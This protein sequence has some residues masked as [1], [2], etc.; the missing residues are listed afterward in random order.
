MV[1]RKTWGGRGQSFF[2]ILHFH[3][4]RR[5]FIVSV[6]V[7]VPVELFAQIIL[8]LDGSG[9]ES[10]VDGLVAL[11]G[12]EQLGQEAHQEVVGGHNVHEEV[13]RHLSDL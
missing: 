3:D 9:L 5:V 11:D 13:I 8:P 6:V 1:T 4:D 2:S 7:K 10:G 12:G